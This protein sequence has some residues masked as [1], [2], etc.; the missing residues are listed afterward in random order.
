MLPFGLYQD[1]SAGKSEQT[2]LTFYADELEKAGIAQVS[3]VAF[4]LYA[5]EAGDYDDIVVGELITLQT[6]AD[7]AAEPA[8]DTTGLELY[9]DGSFRII[10]RDVIL[11]EYGECELDL[12][13]E[14][15][16]GSPVNTFNGQIW[17][18][19]EEVSGYFWKM[20]RPDTRA[21]DNCY[22]Y[23]RADLEITELEQIEEITVDLYVEYMDGM[24]IVETISEKIT[25]EPSAIY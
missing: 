2:Y 15:L 16:S 23:E 14:N 9:N 1:V 18:N 5:Y 6:E 7:G 25:F 24:D 13:M 21:I 20:L 3:E 19:G 10:L 8:V 12:Y 11:D 17:I 22:I 4:E